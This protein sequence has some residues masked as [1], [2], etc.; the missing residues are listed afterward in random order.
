MSALQRPYFIWDYDLTDDYIR[1]ILRGHDE[2]QKAWLVARLLESTRYEDIWGYISLAQLRAIFQKL[3]L[4]PQVRAAWKFAL[5]VW[6][7]EPVHEC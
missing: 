5:L 3:K 7:A 1:A 4:K 6:A 2:E